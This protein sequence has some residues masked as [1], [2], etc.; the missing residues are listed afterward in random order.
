MQLTKIEFYGIGSRWKCTIECGSD[1]HLQAVL[2]W[3]A[4]NPLMPV[5]VENRS[6]SI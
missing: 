3:V 5:T 1:E 6:E 2:D 4:K